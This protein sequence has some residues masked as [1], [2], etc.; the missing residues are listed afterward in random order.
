MRKRWNNVSRIFSDTIKL[1][2][3]LLDHV[4]TH[5]LRFSAPFH[6]SISGSSILS[7]HRAEPVVPSPWILFLP[8]P[9]R[10]QLAGVVIDLLSRNGNEVLLQ[11]EQNVIGYLFIRFKAST[12]K[13][14]LDPA[15][16]IPSR[17]SASSPVYSSTRD[18]EMQ[19]Y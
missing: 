8:P 1:A 4:S 15:T 10:S 19:E 17:C 2:P 6:T 12:V 7:V 5:V 16:Y 18:G 9:F 13:I 14:L 3:H 11:T